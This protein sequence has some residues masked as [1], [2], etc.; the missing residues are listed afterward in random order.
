MA[1][2]QARSIRQFLDYTFEYLDLDWHDYVEIDPRYFRPTEVKVL[3]G[4]YSKAKRVLG[5][6][7]TTSCQELAA[8]MVEHDLDLARNEATKNSLS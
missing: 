3:R 1:T 8:L 5:W 6:E 2:G 7:P 4:D